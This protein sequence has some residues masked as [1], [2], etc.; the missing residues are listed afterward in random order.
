MA[1]EV[2]IIKG[3]AAAAALAA[4]LAL[5][6]LLAQDNEPPQVTTKTVTV[7]HYEDGVDTDGARTEPYSAADFIDTYTDN[8]KGKDFT[9]QYG[10]GYLDFQEPGTYVFSLLVSDEAG[11]T[12][13][14]QAQ[15]VILGVGKREAVREERYGIKTVTS[16]TVTY[17]VEQDGSVTELSRETGDIVKINSAGFAGAAALEPE[18]R[19]LQPELAATREEI[20]GIVNDCRAEEGVGPLLLDEALCQIATVRAMEIAYTGQYSHQRPG[21]LSW[22]TLKEELGY[23]LIAR[24]KLGENLAKGYGGVNADACEGWIHSPLHY[25]N[26]VDP[27]FTR[28]GI[29]RDTLGGATYW[30]QWFASADIAGG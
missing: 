19:A 30:A 29:G 1:G 10:E 27:D 4:A 7:R 9:V 18:A 6:L 14:C 8:R 25:Q 24:T 28:T 13:V 2:K 16:D 5:C 23:S 15:L 22:S 12:A 11:N 21:G 17:R 3:I 20:L 26:M